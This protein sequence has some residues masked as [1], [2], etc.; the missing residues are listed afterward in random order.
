MTVLERTSSKMW[1]AQKALVKDFHSALDFHNI[2]LD[3]YVIAAV[4]HFLGQQDVDRFA[5]ELRSIP[6]NSLQQC[7]RSLARHLLNFSHVSQLRNQP[8]TTRDLVFENMF[9]FV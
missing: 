7:I 4:A 9:L 3:S 1:N 2:I 6:A 8:E 5:I